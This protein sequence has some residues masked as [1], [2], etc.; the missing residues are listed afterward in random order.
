MI[1]EKAK[2]FITKFEEMTF[3]TRISIYVA[4][5]MISHLSASVIYHLGLYNYS[6]SN[7]IPFISSNEITIYSVY[8]SI[9]YLKINYL[10]FC[11]YLFL[12][13]IVIFKNFSLKS[14]KQVN[15][16]KKYH[17]KIIAYLISTADEYRPLHIVYSTRSGVN[18]LLFLIIVM[19]VFSILM[20]NNTTRLA[21]IVIIQYS[22]PIYIGYKYSKQ[23]DFV[24]PFL[25]I[26]PVLIFL[27]MISLLDINVFNKMMKENKIGGELPV[28][29][30]IRTTCIPGKLLLISNKEV[31]IK[32]NNGTQSLNRG[33]IETINYG[34]SKSCKF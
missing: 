15:F 21:L 33:N 28:S 13:S 23:N 9:I 20:L 8:P 32:T 12:I 19:P 25:S 11:L 26:I 16:I 22:L 2:N 30:Q 10:F 4:I 14:E 3:W 31:F 17:E 5:Y 18:A 24:F 29:I 1:V 34:T 27:S 6:L 7:N